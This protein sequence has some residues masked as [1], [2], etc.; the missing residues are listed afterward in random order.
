RHHTHTLF[1]YTTLF[2]STHLTFLF[3]ESHKIMKQVLINE[4]GDVIR[5]WEKLNE[6]ILKKD[7]LTQEE[8]EVALTH[9]ANFLGRT[10]DE[11]KSIYPY[12][13]TETNPNRFLNI[14]YFLGKLA[15]DEVVGEK[16]RVITFSP[17]L[18]ER[19]GHHIHGEEW[20]F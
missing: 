9:T 14:I 17:V 3:L 15:I 19:L 11:V 12:F 10:F 20:A 4:S 5:D 1:P 13:A 2:R 7:D 8:K 6:A 16:Y 18:R